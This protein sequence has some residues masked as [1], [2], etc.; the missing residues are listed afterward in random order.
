MSE[1]SANTPVVVGVGFHQVKSDKPSDC[2]EAIEMMRIAIEDAAKD[3]GNAAI[4]T[5]FDS[6]SVLKGSWPYI[7]PGKML[8][9]KLG[10]SQAKS[11][12]SEIGVLQILPI[13]ELAQYIQDGEQEIGVVVGGEARFRELRSLITGE[14]APNT[15]EPDG[16]PEPDVFYRT[17]D[18]FSSDLE[19]ER[20]VWAPGEFYAIA[21]SAIR[22]NDGLSPD[23]HRDKICEMYAG[24][25]EIASNNPHA[26]FS[27]P[28]SAE[29]LKTIDKKNSYIAYPYSKRLMSQWNVNQSV[30]I[31]IC[32]YAKAKSL[33]LADNGW[34]YPIAGVQQ[35]NVVNLAQKPQLHSHPGTAMIGERVLE[36]ANLSINDI[37]RAE[38]YSPFPSAVQ[39]CKKDLKLTDQPITATGSMAFAGGPFN[40]GAVD[41][42]ARLVEVLR[43]QKDQ[44]KD[45]YAIVTSISGMFGKQGIGLFSTQPMARDF[46]FDDITEQVKAAEPAIEIDAEYQGNAV[47]VGY[48][49]MYNKADVSHVVAYCD[50][51]QGKRTVVRSNDAEFAEKWT[52]EELVGK[53]VEVKAGGD[54][55][56]AEASAGATV[57]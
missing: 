45:E 1:F 23:A 13:L 39:A 10:C 24:F 32:S 48:S 38:L 15:E 17:P 22:H 35:R 12:Q 3:A 26:W 4:V 44:G 16:T 8:A 53:T 33:G 51:P 5:E 52:Q 50:T 42:V 2:P 20:G 29:T 11:Y 43:E 55:V 18:A 49:V 31:I 28:V 34:V 54:F 56:L 57:A 21:E 36:M 37:D 46:L 25:S 47:V 41:S 9:D 19:A 27:E 30:A 14:P 6:I 40:H 7:N